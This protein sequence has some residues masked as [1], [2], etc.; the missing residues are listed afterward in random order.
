MARLSDKVQLGIGTPTL[1][2][3]VIVLSARLDVDTRTPLARF[4]DE[5]GITVVQFGEAH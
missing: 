1:T 3:T 5:A 2:E 4:L